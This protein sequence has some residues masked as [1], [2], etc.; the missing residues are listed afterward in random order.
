MCFAMKHDK[1]NRCFW[2]G[3]CTKQC[4]LLRKWTPGQCTHFVVSY[5]LHHRLGHLG[6]RTWLWIKWNK[7]FFVNKNFILIHGASEP[8]I[9]LFCLAPKFCKNSFHP[10][11]QSWFRWFI[12]LVHQTRDS[13]HFMYKI[14]LFLKPPIWVCVLFDLK[15]LWMP[16]KAHRGLFNC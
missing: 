10:N 9:K 16:I 11:L 7:I 4:N 1:L 3:S 6:P 13:F 14:N 5:V 15:L 2:S 12:Y 8:W